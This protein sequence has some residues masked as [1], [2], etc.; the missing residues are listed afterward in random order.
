MD[1]GCLSVVNPSGFTSRTNQRICAPQ[2]ALGC[3]ADIRMVGLVSAFE[4]FS[5]CGS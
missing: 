5:C 4:H 1:D 2:K 3:G